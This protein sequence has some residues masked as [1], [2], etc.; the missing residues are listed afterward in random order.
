MLNFDITLL[1]NFWYVASCVLLVIVVALAYTALGLYAF[2][3]LRK[4][5]K[6]THT[7]Q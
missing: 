5:K 1:V 7:Q 3:S 4:H 6:N 2:R